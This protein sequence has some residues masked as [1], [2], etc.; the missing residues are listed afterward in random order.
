[1]LVGGLFS[2]IGGIELGLEQAGMEIAWHCE[3]DPFRRAVLKTHWPHVP[4]YEDV[5]LLSQP[6]HVDV[7]C[8]GFPCQDI[9]EAGRRAG[10]EGERSGLWSEF[11]RIIGEVHPSWVVIE[12]VTA[13]RRRGLDV[14]LRDLASLGYDAG[15]DRLPAAVVGAPHR[16]ERL[17]IVAYDPA[18]GCDV[19]TGS[20]PSLT[21]GQ[22]WRRPAYADRQPLPDTAF[23]WWSS[24][25]PGF[26]TWLRS[27]AIPPSPFC[28]VDD[29]FPNRLDRRRRVASLGDAVVPAVA[30]VIGRRIMAC[31]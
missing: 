16:R 27:S 20:Q 17:W 13:L 11:A 2:G 28:G 21:Q 29:V 25:A 19:W 22:R 30:E 3:I 14:V 4:C 31:K 23:T 1:M 6:P 12:N 26:S 8:G 18:T 10:I 15:W 5:R 7:L 24:A 9:S